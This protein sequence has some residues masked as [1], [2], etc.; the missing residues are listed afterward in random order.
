MCELDVYVKRPD[1]S[2]KIASEVI[3]AGVRDGRLVV[4]DI[5]GSEKKFENSMISELDINRERL[6]LIESPIFRT[7]LEFIAAYED[8]VSKGR[9]QSGLQDRWEDVKACGDQMVRNL[10]SKFEKVEVS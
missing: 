10:W 1:S 8:S 2:E 5:V 3:Y 4:R 6:E 7:V 9:Y